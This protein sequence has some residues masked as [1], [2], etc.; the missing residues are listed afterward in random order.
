MVLCCGLIHVLH[1][2]LSHFV[3]CTELRVL[4]EVDPS[5]WSL[6]DLLVS[7]QVQIALI[8]DLLPDV[9]KAGIR[10]HVGLIQMQSHRIVRKDAVRNLI[11]SKAL[12]V[13]QKSEVLVDELF[14]VFQRLHQLGEVLGELD[15]TKEHPVSFSSTFHDCLDRRL[16]CVV[17]VDFFDQ[18]AFIH[19]DEAIFESPPVLLG[20]DLVAVRLQDNSLSQVL[21]SSLVDLNF[22]LIPRIG[23]VIQLRDDKVS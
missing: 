14:V 7:E 4:D 9:T 12:E 17:K 15:G 11:L 19:V 10:V 23:N 20:N 16:L 22:L 18:V 1:A 6:A 5:D 13:D 21:E 2:L 3:P 8:Q